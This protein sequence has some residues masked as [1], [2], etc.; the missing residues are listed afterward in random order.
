MFTHILCS[1]TKE[2][3]NN[4]NKINYIRILGFSNKGKK[5]L[6][7]I[8]KEVNIPIITNINKHNVDLL[9]TELRA[10]NIYNIITERNDY[11]YKKRPIIKDVE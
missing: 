9:N 7:K 10:D 1:Y 2:E 4:N 8:K 5:Y 6:N 11:I 3:N